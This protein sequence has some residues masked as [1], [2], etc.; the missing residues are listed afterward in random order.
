MDR[1]DFL[2]VAGVAGAT[3]LL[4]SVGRAA[5]ESDLRIVEVYRKG[6][7]LRGSWPDLKKDTI[8]RLREEDGTLTDAGTS[9]EISVVVTETRQVPHPD[10]VSENWEVGCEPFTIIG[11]DHVLAKRV[12]VWKDGQ[13]VG[14]VRVVDL[15]HGVMHRWQKQVD[16]D[17]PAGHVV[18][19]IEE[20]ETFDYI[21]V[22]PG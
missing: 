13:R 16:L 6:K 2:K 11:M 1:R 18:V 4:P 10:G 20:A 17:I 19:P 21:E 5:P 15:K 7:W 12:R 22:V 8:F 3:V 14:F 9:H